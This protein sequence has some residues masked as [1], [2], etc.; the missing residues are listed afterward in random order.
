[1]NFDTNIGANHGT[2]IHEL[3]EKL[4][5]QGV[6]ESMVKELQSDISDSDLSAVMSF[7]ENEIYTKLSQGK[8]HHEY[9]FYALIDNEV[10]HGYMDMVSFTDEATYLVDYK[11]DRVDSSET[12]LELYSDQLLAYTKVLKQLRP[13]QAV[14]TYLYSLSLKS[15]IPVI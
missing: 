8:I 15:F 11:T 3:F 10:L 12:L 5:H 6:T 14:K 9:P 4:P 1:L 13:E 2:L 7:Y